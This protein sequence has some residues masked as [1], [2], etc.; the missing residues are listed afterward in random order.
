MGKSDSKLDRYLN[1]LV[2]AS[3]FVV[4]LLVPDH[5]AAMLLPYLAIS[6]QRVT[7]IAVDK[8]TGHLLNVDVAGLSQNCTNAWK[9]HQQTTA[10]KAT[11]TTTK[12]TTTYP[13]DGV[14]SLVPADKS[15]SHLWN[16][17]LTEILHA[18][19]SLEEEDIASHLVTSKLLQFLTPSRY[20]EIGHRA[21]PSR[22]AW[23]N[24]LEKVHARMTSKDA[25]VVRVVVFG[26]V[27][28]SCSNNHHEPNEEQGQDCLWPVRLEHLINSMLRSGDA[29]KKRKIVKI[30][31]KFHPLVPVT[32]EFDT[33]I[34]KNGLWKQ[35]PDVIISSFTAEDMYLPK[36]GWDTATD[37]NYY[38]HRRQVIQEF[39]RAC[40]DL[41]PC[42][43]QQSPLLINIDDYVVG[44]AHNNQ[45][46]QLGPVLAETTQARVLQLL[47]DYYGTA[48]VSYAEVVRKLVYASKNLHSPLVQNL[49]KTLSS[50]D[51]Q[52]GTVDSE[53]LGPIAMTLTLA[54]SFLKYTVTYCSDQAIHKSDE[55]NPIIALSIRQLAETV[56]PQLNTDLCLT[57]VTKFWEEEHQHRN[58]HCSGA[59]LVARATA[60]TT[61][62]CAF[63][64][65][66]STQAT[67]QDLEGYL[68]KFVSDKRGWEARPG[69]QL[70]ATQNGAAVSFTFPV[71]SASQQQKRWS[72]Q[73]FSTVKDA[74]A[75]SVA[76]KLKWEVSARGKRRSRRLEQQQ[77]A[78]S[79][80]TSGIV[81]GTHDSPHTVALP[82]T[83]WL[84]NLQGMVPSHVDL[85]LELVEGD[86]F[87]IVA[88]M[89]CSSDSKN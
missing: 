53:Y 77:N 4:V 59:E 26:A 27:P 10:E 22:Q 1:G 39:I 29:D 5:L 17:H 52:H 19:S 47:S 61:S 20:L 89:F 67:E 79:T 88:M 66:G 85:K 50:S 64:F 40:L 31:P 69:G 51:R 45:L 25:P 87:E 56:P 36:R 34:V 38:H 46:V 41:Q 28:H 16:E 9:S 43:R 48:L 3:T 68:T 86:E 23:G 78:T 62:S 42:P 11:A 49:A 6:E 76:S 70:V 18:A 75:S 72:I 73:L 71:P 81:E 54:Y 80:S 35:Q 58:E 15:S 63:A 33:A 60:A 32:T 8:N 82:S 14:C 84:D 57:N 44:N 24:L 30:T 21:Q 7:T 55:E 12:T 83:I 2:L 37:I 65:W 74:A 13:G